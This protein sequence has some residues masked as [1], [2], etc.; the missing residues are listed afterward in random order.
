MSPAT[1]RVSPPRAVSASGVRVATSRASCT[2][3]IAAAMYRR[4]SV[5]TWA[6][7]HWLYI[8]TFA[9]GA[10]K[11]G[12]A[13]DARKRVRLDEQGAVRATY[14]ARTDDGL[15]VRVLEDAVTEHVGVPQTRH[16]T[17]KA[18]A[19]TRALP[20]TALD[21]AHVDCVAAVEAHLRT[22]GLCARSMPH[23]AWQ[24]PALHAA[25]F[26]AGRGIHPV[27][28]HPVT[29]GSHCLTPVSLVGSVALVQVNA[30]AEAE[31]EAE[32]AAGDAADSLMLVDLDALGG[33]R[34]TFDDAARSPESVAQHSLF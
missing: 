31:A 4:R 5:A 24:P 10:H 19:L 23:E 3:R 30:A 13:S 25:F 14:V 7:P 33:R 32:G 17:S 12:T 18:A 9:D 8:A 27:Y 2:T 21:V 1:A 28:A 26:D 16:K 15:A 22:R 11:V 6:Q 29:G 34:V 20:E